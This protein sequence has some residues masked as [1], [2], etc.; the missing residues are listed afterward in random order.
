MPYFS[1]LQNN[2]KNILSLDP[3]LLL[4]FISPHTKTLCK[5]Y[6]FLLFQSLASHF[7][8]TYF[9]FLS[10]ITPVKLLLSS[11]PVTSKL[12]NTMVYS[13]TSYHLICQPHL[14]Q[15]IILFFLKHFLH[16]ASKT[17]CFWFSSYLTSCSFSCL[18]DFSPSPCSLNNGVP[19]GKFFR[20]FF[21]WIY[22]NFVGHLI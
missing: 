17:P 20:Q 12:L 22:I 3:T 11:S 6:L 8:S 21:F 7:P 16:F 19:Q 14:L 13:Q 1:F 15:F 4:I 10:P 2:N 5:T 18:A 9:K